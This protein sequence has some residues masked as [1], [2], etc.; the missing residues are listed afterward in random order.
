MRLFLI[1]PVAVV[2][3]ACQTTHDQKDWDVPLTL[4]TIGPAYADYALEKADASKDGTITLVEWTRAG[5]SR[6]SFLL[7]DENKDGV[8][9]RAELLRFGSNAK[10]FDQTRRY[11]DFN[12]DNR[13]TP[14]DFR[15]PGGV[16]VL[17]VEF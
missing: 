8:V 6:K 7:V 4:Q 17:R 3:A 13:I 11:V 10:F 2:L 5:G 12:K 16:R 1:L 9:T 15:T 14:R